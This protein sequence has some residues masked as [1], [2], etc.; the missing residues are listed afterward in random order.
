MCIIIDAN[1][2]GDLNGPT[3]DGAPILRWLLTGGGGLIIGGKLRRELSRS[4]KMRLTM[5]ALSQ[6]GKLHSLD[7]EKVQTLTDN[8]KESCCSDDPHVIAAA[9]A[10]G[11]RLI[12]SRDQ[13]LHK[14]A[15]NK[16]IL[17]PAA[18]IYQNKAHKHLL[19]T[20]HCT[21]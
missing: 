3:E 10:S 14:D 17:S 21:K 6:A 16:D 12:F 20:C 4:S 15:K 19:E 1:V 13:N 11:C 18:T 8:L 2:I 9:V 7:E 5:V